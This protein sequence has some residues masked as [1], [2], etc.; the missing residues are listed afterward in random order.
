MINT[1]VEL[2][3]LLEYLWVPGVAIIGWL[4]RTLSK[5]SVACQILTQRVE[6][7]EATA[8]RLEEAV[9]HD[10]H[11]ITRLKEKVSRLEKDWS[12]LWTT[13]RR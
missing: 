7:L 4:W 3:S 12:N 10:G 6:S 5:T 1:L 9:H 2:T 8:A 11:D 13:S